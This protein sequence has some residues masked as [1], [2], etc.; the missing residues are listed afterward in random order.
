VDDPRLTPFGQ[1]TPEGALTP[2][3]GD[4]YLF[5]SGRDDIHNIL[6]TLIAA[7]TMAY[8]WNMFGYDDDAINAVILKML[9]NPNIFVQGTLDKSQSRGVHERKLLAADVLANPD[10]YNSVIVTE[11]ATHQISHTKGGVLVGQG[12]FYE[13]SVNWSASGEGEGINL[14]GPQAKGFKAQNNTLIVS[15][16][17]VALSRFSARLDVEHVQVINRARRANQVAAS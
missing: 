13:A 10:F 17:P 6:L 14:A 12:L 7:E 5:F 8:K 2:G 11:S 9:G 1:F 16:N 15:S 4:S 3:Y